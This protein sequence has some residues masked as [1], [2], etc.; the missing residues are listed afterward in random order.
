[1][2]IIIIIFASLVILIFGCSDS[3]AEQC[4]TCN[5]TGNT[6]QIEDRDTRIKCM[7]CNGAGYILE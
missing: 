5:G 3:K 1:M 4:G 6:F 7:N 2:K